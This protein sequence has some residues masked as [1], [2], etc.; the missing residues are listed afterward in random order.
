MNNFSKYYCCYT[1]ALLLIF[2]SFGM[3]QTLNK[4]DKEVLQGLWISYAKNSASEGNFITLLNRGVD[5]NT[6]DENGAT[7]LMW[8]AL[9]GNWT[10]MEFLLNKGANPNIKGII[11]LKQN[12]PDAYAGS[13]LSA[14]VISGEYSAV[15]ILY[16]NAKQ[17]PFEYD[18]APPNNTTR[19]TPL[20]RACNEIQFINVF[21]YGD[22]A[23]LQKSKVDLVATMSMGDFTPLMLAAFVNDEEVCKRLLWAG[24]NP[25]LRNK[26]GQT[27]LQ[28]AESKGYMDVVS[29]LKDK[30]APQNVTQHSKAETKKIE[31]IPISI[32]ERFELEAHLHE[33][34][35]EKAL[36]QI[37]YSRSINER[38]KEG[39]L[40]FLAK[41]QRA[42]ATYIYQPF[43]YEDINRIEFIKSL[44]FY[45]TL[46]RQS[47]WELNLS[48]QNQRPG[49]NNYNINPHHVL[50]YLYGKNSNSVQK[51]IEDITS[52]TSLIWEYIPKNE[53]TIKQIR[54]HLSNFQDPIRS[55][56]SLQI[57][58]LGESTRFS[59]FERTAIEPEE[60]YAPLLDKMDKEDFSNPKIAENVIRILFRYAESQL[61][62]APEVDKLIKKAR[63]I[64]Q[65]SNDN[66]ILLRF[67]WKAVNIYLKLGT[68]Q[69][70]EECYQK[71]VQLRQ[72]IPDNSLFYADEIIAECWL[73]PKSDSQSK[74]LKIQDALS[75]IETYDSLQKN[76]RQRILLSYLAETYQ[77]IGNYT[78]ALTLYHKLWN[79][80]PYKVNNYALLLS[81][82][83]AQC[84]QV[85][86]QYEDFEIYSEKANEIVQKLRLFFAPTIQDEPN[87]VI[88][89]EKITDGFKD[90]FEHYQSL[91]GEVILT[92]NEAL[93]SIY[94]KDKNS[95]VENLLIDNEL[96]QSRYLK[97]MI[98]QGNTLVVEGKL[99][100]A[101]RL[102][103]NTLKRISELPAKS[104]NAFRMEQNLYL[105]WGKMGKTFEAEQGL[106]NLKLSTLKEWG[107]YSDVYTDVLYELI[108]YYYQNNKILPLN[109]SLSEMSEVI[110]KRQQTLAAFML[111]DFEY[112]T[113]L[114]LHQ[115]YIDQL[116]NICVEK[117]TTNPALGKIVANYL[118]NSRSLQL[119]GQRIIR[120]N[121]RVSS[122]DV[123]HKMVAEIVM[124]MHERAARRADF[125][126]Q[127]HKEAV[128]DAMKWYGYVKKYNTLKARED[129]FRSWVS[130]K[131]EYG[132]EI[133]RPAFG[134]INVKNREDYL[135]L[136]GQM[137]D[138]VSMFVNQLTSFD[139]FNLLNKLE[140]HQAIV[141]YFSYT[142]LGSMGGQSIKYGAI[143]YTHQMKNPMIV[144]LSEENE[145]RKVIDNMKDE[146]AIDKAYMSFHLYNL[147]W[148]PIVPFL[149]GIKEVS[150]IPT[151]ILNSIA[152]SALQ[153][154][155]NKFLFTSFELK[156][157][158]NFQNAFG[159]SI[160]LYNDE[161]ISAD[162]WG[163]I[164]YDKKPE[165]IKTTNAPIA[166][167]GVKVELSRGQNW[168]YL[169]GTE[170][171]INAIQKIL[172]T[173]PQKNI[174]TFTHKKA[175]EYD[176][177]SKYTSQTQPDILHVATHGFYDKMLITGQS[178]EIQ[179]EYYRS[180]E[181]MLNAG[182]ALAGAN[183]SDVINDADEEDGVL[184]ALEISKLNINSKLVVLSACESG[185][186]EQKSNEG[187][188]GLQ[189]AFKLAGADYLLMTLWQI[190]DRETSEMMKLFYT[191]LARKQSIEAAFNNAQREM[192]KKYS[193][194]YWAGFVLIR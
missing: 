172:K 55:N 50:N 68:P 5:I 102:Y 4:Q 8:A 114:N 11:Y 54:N 25:N 180:S 83:M 23:R 61:D 2:S 67:Y 146:Q 72:I 95:E 28:I 164:D 149:E 77:S 103:V 154:E 152:F 183:D 93:L 3:A 161:Q 47:N 127:K 16:E 107:L 49:S 43:D 85:L 189:R 110:N 58:L 141:E 30:T 22:N 101:E 38:T 20:H 63:I 36:T 91:M 167:R 62:N 37:K 147:L 100:E 153:D 19:I 174:S 64:A 84:Y 70:A 178:D 65:K 118:L 116:L 82:K 160:V 94:K 18:V 29:V 53:K 121:F 17:S 41:G 192:M 15:K 194:F 108:N 35:G 90:F 165:R 66:E 168:K 144:T 75:Q 185:L 138:S 193:P 140:P 79:I 176:F 119:K 159:D 51:L 115:K 45:H 187:V 104:S 105:L 124:P 87:P 179:E 26:K 151:G 111:G 9:R 33:Q 80:V 42:F 128:A 122:R 186:G 148:K 24:A 181:S 86:H 120:E 188:F 71:A 12:T 126:S 155:N 182:L 117:S 57:E 69:L 14:A 10:L 98:E 1:L 130:A 131:I 150:Y 125:G 96:T 123:T 34:A 92:T 89:K 7:A 170:I 59:V 137:I 46:S 129:L 132:R 88:Q 134:D 184:T 27:A 143:V 60:Y 163:A 166:L 113:F 145:V 32:P 156:R 52:T 135:N 139:C 171:E 6:R 39:A 133:D 169:P 78:E 74:I 190:P 99:K 175:G 48:L 40:S 112:D 106:K 76:T 44:L 177:K 31:L 173:F 97:S 73:Y 158:T 157:L 191:G 81:I 162:L 56:P 136:E 13:V 21:L 109:E 142:D